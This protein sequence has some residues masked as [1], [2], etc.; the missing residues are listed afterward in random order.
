M[1][2]VHRTVVRYA[3]D[4]KFEFRL[5][6]NKTHFVLLLKTV[7]LLLRAYLDLAKRPV[8]FSI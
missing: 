3:Q 6:L 2:Q 7:M 8:N 1:I 5:L 4:D